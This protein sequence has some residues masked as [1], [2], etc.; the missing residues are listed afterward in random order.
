VS[1]AVV[2][3]VVAACGSS[4]S[5]SN[6]SPNTTAGSSSAPAGSSVRVM[7]ISIGSAAPATLSSIEFPD[8]DTVV[9]AEAAYVNAHGGAGGHKVVVDTCYD[10]GDPNIA[11]TCARKAVSNKDV[12][13]TAP[14]AIT[15]D[16]ILPVLAAAHIPYFGSTPVSPDD[17][18]N[19][20]SFPIAGGIPIDYGGEG[21]LLATHGC[22]KVGILYTDSSQESAGVP[23]IAK[24][25]ESN[26][27]QVVAK[28]A[29]P[30]T[31]VNAAPVVAQIE[32]AG[33]TCMATS[34]SPNQGPPVV[35][36]ANQSGKKLTVS[37]ITAS[38]PNSLLK[39]LGPAA[40]GLLLS[41]P[42]SLPSDTQN[43]SIKQMLA[44]SK[45]YEGSSP[46]PSSNFAVL[47]WAGANLLFGKVIPSITGPVTGAS[48]TSAIESLK[49]ATTGVT[50]PYTGSAPA[51][52][53]QY[54]RLINY[55][56]TFW[57][58]D[59]GLPKSIQKGFVNLTKSVS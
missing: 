25:A 55:G 57:Q 30:A 9:E 59:N 7:V 13:V 22:K 42:E 29:F 3:L 53:S 15:A 10:Q 48:V 34:L 56:T 44:V 28:V 37:G 19:P 11:A 5:S 51:P 33:A 31:S 21:A 49:G 50:Q 17:Y 1:L 26:G 41:G 27:A 6:S 32:D 18:V 4:N 47:G 46:Q 38:F 43:P 2:S 52:L 20:D 8:V 54:P 14:L 24:G 12:A 23:Y 58:V 35:L 16:S 45:Q 39:T 36:A 40:N